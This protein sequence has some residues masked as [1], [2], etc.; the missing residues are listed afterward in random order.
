MSTLIVQWKHGSNWLPVHTYEVC[1]A[2]MDPDKN[3]EGVR[4]GPCRLTPSA[5]VFTISMCSTVVDIP[6]IYTLS[7]ASKRVMKG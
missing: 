2:C 6:N 1:H 7:L 5:E 3:S 4:R